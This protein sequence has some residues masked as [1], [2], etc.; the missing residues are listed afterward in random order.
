MRPGIEEGNHEHIAFRLGST[1]YEIGMAYRRRE[2]RQEDC[3]VSNQQ[4][5][6]PPERSM[7]IHK[8]VPGSE[9]HVFRDCGHLPSIEKPDETIALLR[10]WLDRS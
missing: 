1:G 2:R 5:T 3:G 4:P 9:L 6:T 8:A 7:D 10:N